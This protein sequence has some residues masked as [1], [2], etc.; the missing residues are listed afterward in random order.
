MLDEPPLIVRTPGENFFVLAEVFFVGDFAD[1]CFIFA[2]FF[3]FLVR[4]SFKDLQ[5]K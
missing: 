1:G 2:R 3:I 4:K 5:H